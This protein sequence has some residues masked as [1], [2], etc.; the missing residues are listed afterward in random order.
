MQAHK[1]NTNM[2]E[3]H[4]FNLIP[5]WNIWLEVLSDWVIDGRWNSVLVWNTKVRVEAG[6]KELV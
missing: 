5:I 1:V 3:G 4:L 2:Q 6:Q